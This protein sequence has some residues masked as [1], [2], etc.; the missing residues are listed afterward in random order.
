VSEPIDADWERVGSLDELASGELQS[1][2]LG[3]EEIVVC[4]IGDDVFALHGWCT[5]A[6]ARLSRARC[7]AMSCSV[8]CTKAAS[9]CAAGRALCAPV[10]TDVRVFPVRIVDGEVQAKWK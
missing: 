7:T 4:R 2:M 8:L 3:D 9:M 10:D 6:D 5:H 1:S